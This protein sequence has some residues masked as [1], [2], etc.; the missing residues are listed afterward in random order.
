MHERAGFTHRGAWVKT[1]NVEA[2]EPVEW[3]ERRP[4]SPEALRGGYSAL[5]EGMIAH[6]VF[7]ILG[8]ALGGGSFRKRTQS[9]GT[10]LKLAVQQKMTSHLRSS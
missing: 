4:E 3:R 9:T 8:K 7:N 2:C 1:S 6:P 10:D 5:G